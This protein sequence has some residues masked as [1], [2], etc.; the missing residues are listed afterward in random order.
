MGRLLVL[1][2]CLDRVASLTNSSLS[3]NAE[4]ETLSL[5]LTSHI[6]FKGRLL[7]YIYECN[8]NVYRQPLLAGHNTV[9]VG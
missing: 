8:R 2:P 7:K 4:S 5:T 9:K 1:L 3:H 6:K